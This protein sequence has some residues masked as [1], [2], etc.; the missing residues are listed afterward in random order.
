M[1]VSF[2]LF[3]FIFLSVK[4]FCQDSTIKQP[5]TQIERANL[6]IG[7]V[8]RKEFIDL[9]KYTS[10]GIFVAGDF[11]T[12]VL[13]I[14]DAAS[15]IETSGIIV[16]AYVPGS[17]YTSGKTYSAYIDAD[18]VAALVK[19]LELCENLKD[20]TETNYTE[21]IFN[22][23]DLQFFAYYSENSKKKQFEWHFGM[24]VDKYYK[25]SRV[26]IDIKTMTEFKTAVL[27]NMNYFK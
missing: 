15:G 7:S 6:K 17:S 23:R 27:N 13:K 21:Y 19:F 26:D 22:S 24:E 3:V 8:I 1:K 4:S 20:K 5:S 16:R 9:Y 25:D 2:L 10:K 14:K 11:T 12:Q 18:E